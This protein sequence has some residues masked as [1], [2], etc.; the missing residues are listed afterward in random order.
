M[1]A[2]KDGKK[3]PFLHSKYV[4]VDSKWSA[5]GSW[6]MWTR[7]AFYEMEAEICVHSESFASELEGKFERESGKYCISVKTPEECKQFL[8]Q[9][10]ELCEGFGPFYGDEA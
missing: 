1:T 8:P 3:P 9:G 10:C 5:V 2:M 4:V 7:S 6:N